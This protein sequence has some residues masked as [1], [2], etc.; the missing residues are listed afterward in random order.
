MLFFVGIGV[1]F[2]SCFLIATS[3]SNSAKLV[4]RW[5]LIDNQINYPTLTFQSDSLAIFGSRGDTVYRFKYYVKA[6]TLYLI[7]PEGEIV[8]N[9]ILNISND[10]LRFESLLENKTVQAYYKCKN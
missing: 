7:R 5:C 2:A 9:K 8:Q 4:G 1:M 6:Q 10:S 3:R